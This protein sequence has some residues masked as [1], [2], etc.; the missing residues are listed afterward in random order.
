[1]AITDCGCTCCTWVAGVAS[2]APAR[3][4]DSILMSPMV[5]LS[6]TPTARCNRF[7]GP[8]F[9]DRRHVAMRRSMERGV[10]L[11]VLKLGTT[12]AARE[13]G[14]NADRSAGNE[15][16]RGFL[17]ARSSWGVIGQVLPF[18][19]FKKSLFERLIPFR[20]LPHA[21]SEHLIKRHRGLTT[22][23]RISHIVRMTNDLL[24]LAADLVRRRHSGKV[25]KSSQTK[26]HR[27]QLTHN[28]FA[29][30]L[31]SIDGG[32]FLICSHFYRTV[33]ET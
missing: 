30:H 9:D 17:R 21:V 27:P 32:R 24:I 23:K 26:N 20:N 16:F 11:S 2:S 14:G 15:V 5:T 29:V 3:E 31:A 4:V 13:P 33:F 28:R 22:G 8:L 18:I 7:N 6:R 12:H 1:L 10:A 25:V 19:H